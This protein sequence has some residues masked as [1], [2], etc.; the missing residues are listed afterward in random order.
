[1]ANNMN[2]NQAFASEKKRIKFMYGS[3]FFA[4]RVGILMQAIAT[5]F[6]LA[7]WMEGFRVYFMITPAVFLVLGWVIVFLSVSSIAN[8][9]AV[10]YA[11]QNAIPDYTPAFRDV[12]SAMGFIF[13]PQL[14]AT[15][16]F[17][18]IIT[19]YT[20]SS[21][22]SGYVPVSWLVV[23]SQFLLTVIILNAMAALM[24][25]VHKV[26]ENQDLPEE[27]T[28]MQK[29]FHC[30]SH[31]VC[32]NKVV[33]IVVLAVLVGVNFG[34]FIYCQN[35]R[36]DARLRSDE[37]K[38]TE[39]VEAEEQP[40]EEISYENLTREQ[41]EELVASGQVASMEELEPYIVADTEE[42]LANLQ[43]D[44]NAGELMRQVI[45]GERP[46]I[47]KTKSHN[48][49][50]TTGDEYAD[51]TPVT[52]S[53]SPDIF[54]YTSLN[55]FE[56][57]IPVAMVCKHESNNNSPIYY[58]LAY[59]NGEIYGTAVSTHG[60]Q[61]RVQDGPFF[62]VSSDYYC[63]YLRNDPYGD[64]STFSLYEEYVTDPDCGEC[65]W[66][67]LTDENLNKVFP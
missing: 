57:C 35:L 51:G 30:V 15:I 20:T 37:A 40:T 54:Y 26:P 59:S 10:E 49:P 5:A 19:M 44:E 47:Y 21:G 65:P 34:S 14:F 36:E 7:Q 53:Y 18:V 11:Q 41:A 58:V 55:G 13:R 22:S 12:R 32:Y 24:S 31:V 39:I 62:Y 33:A 16:L 64:P 2:Q 45:K 46:F 23:V 50:Y 48:A 25:G 56:S 6:I 3:K 43:S 42:D 29:L 60:E 67:Y 38:N 61:Y 66:E 8:G 9:V 27:A 28:L 4:G 52:F 17:A 63:V 1:M